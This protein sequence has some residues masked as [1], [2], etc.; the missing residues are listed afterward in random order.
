MSADTL[1]PPPPP[2]CLTRSYVSRKIKGGTII[3]EDVRDLETHHRKLLDADEYRSAIGACWACGSKVL[4]ALCLRERIL[5]G[6]P[7][8]PP[9]VETIR[10]YRCAVKACGAVFTIL[11]AVIARHLWRLWKTVEGAAGGK[12]EVPRSTFR[13]WL[14]RLGSSARQ[15]VQTLTSKAS[16]LISSSL[17]SALLRVRTRSDLAKTFRRSLVGDVESFAPL[18]AWIHRLE[19]GIRL[20]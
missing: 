7:D 16:S 20:M 8:E 12:L 19:P 3:A 5:R 11:P 9:L 6:A 14:G 18:A 2:V 4:H 13:R 10:M 1:P 17:C 15:L